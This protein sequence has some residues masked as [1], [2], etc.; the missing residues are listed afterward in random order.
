MLYITN[1]LT[2]GPLTQPVQ[3]EEVTDHVFLVPFP[4]LIDDK[5]F[6]ETRNIFWIYNL[7]TKLFF[8]VMI[9]IRSTNPLHDL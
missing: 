4:V 8:Y 3:R 7:Y 6:C 2:S 1:S 5:L 9:I